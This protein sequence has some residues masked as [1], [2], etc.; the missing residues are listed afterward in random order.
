MSSLA[1]L[2]VHPLIVDEELGEL[3]RGARDSRHSAKYLQQRYQFHKYNSRHA[4]NNQGTYIHTMA[5]VVLFN[6]CCTVT[7][8]GKGLGYFLAQGYTG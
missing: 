8:N 7:V 4:H 3:H 6:L 2:S 1:R 5:T